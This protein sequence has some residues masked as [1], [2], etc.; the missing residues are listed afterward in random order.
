MRIALVRAGMFPAQR[1]DPREV[2]SHCRLSG[3]TLN[4]HAL[5]HAM[6]SELLRKL[7]LI[8]SIFYLGFATMAFSQSSAP[9]LAQQTKSSQRSNAVLELPASTTSVSFEKGSVQFIG[10]AT[11]IIRYAGF[12]ILTD[13]NFLH[14]GDHVHLGYGLK[15]KR[16]TEPAIAL[17]KLPPIDLIV[18]SHFHGDHFDQLVQKKLDRAIPIVT[19]DAAGK[20]L[21]KLGFTSRHAI[22]KWSTLT[23]KKGNAQLRI[24]ATPARHGPPGAA[25]ALPETMGSIL[26]FAKE[27]NSAS[28]RMYISGDTLV[29]DEIRDIPKRFPNINLALLHLGGTKILKTV[30]V[31]MDAEQGVEMMKIIAPQHAIP[32]HYNDYDVFKSPIEDFEKR[33]KAAG[34]QNK[35]TYLKH[36]ESYQIRTS[37]KP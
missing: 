16:L 3:P 23:V 35:V 2:F 34:L 13:P 4:D 25:V 20:E 31:T 26:E 9:D 27:D 22:P 14:K 32:I 36:G 1:I 5:E 6:F 8:P 21:E 30:L 19:T 12:T 29:Y 18:L 33:I 28:Y 11:V 37:A 10:N 24:T 15:S 7:M 17:E